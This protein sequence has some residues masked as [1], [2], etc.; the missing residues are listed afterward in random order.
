MDRWTDRQMDGLIDGWMGWWESISDN[1][2]W[3]PTNNQTATQMQEEMNINVCMNGITKSMN[4]WIN[5]Q[6]TESINQWN[7][8]ISQSINDIN[9]FTSCWKTWC[10][11]KMSDWTNIKMN[12]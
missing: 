5:E 4:E 11:K 6:T 3:T 8:S 9:Q 10:D 7:E 12:K 2:G 1:W